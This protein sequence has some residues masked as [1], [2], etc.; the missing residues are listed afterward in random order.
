MT[1]KVYNNEKLVHHG[2]VKDFLAANNNDT[3]LSQ[4]CMYLNSQDKISFNDFI[5]GNWEIAKV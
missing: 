2:S 3:Y 5:T 4:V 1:I